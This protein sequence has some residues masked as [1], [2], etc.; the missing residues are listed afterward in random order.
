V[1]DDV[2]PERGKYTIRVAMQQE[3]AAQTD[4]GTSTTEEGAD[5]PTGTFHTVIRRNEGTA[6]GAL[7]LNLFY[8]TGSEFTTTNDLAVQAAV[9][10]F[11]SDLE[12]FGIS[13]G[14]IQ[15]FD[16]QSGTPSALD[17]DDQTPLSGVYRLMQE[18]KRA[19]N[20][21]ALNVFFVNEVKGTNP[22]GKVTLPG[23]SVGTPVAL[24]VGASN[25]S[26]IVM[27]T[28]FFLAA[29][30][31]SYDTTLMG[32]WL[33]HNLGHAV[34]L[35]HTTEGYIKDGVVHDLIT[36]TVECPAYADIDGDSILTAAEC[37]DSDGSNTM[38]WDI[39]PTAHLTAGQG[40]MI[41]HSVIVR[42]EP[43]NQ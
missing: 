7:D 29:E 43:R 1:A 12:P 11:F 26:G 34:G 3:A 10:T 20:N 24:G 27:S 41:R 15:T 37:Q 36:D 39:V 33:V 22:L 21:R 25:H 32:H 23:V 17:S 13:R 16:V 30:T 38:F 42:G 9:D 8:V 4:G 18:A 28:Q 2:E 35:Q 14:T 5:A 40:Y 6:R 19:S 31:G